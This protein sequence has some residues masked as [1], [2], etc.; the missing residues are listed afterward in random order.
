MLLISAGQVGNNGMK[1]EER[2][3]EIIHIKKIAIL[4]L[5]IILIILAI[6]LVLLKTFKI[7]TVVVEGNKHY[8]E[9]EIQDMVMGGRFGDNSLFL[10]VK[11]HNKSITDIPFIQ[12]MDVEVV[13]RNTIKISVYEKNLAG[14]VE[15]LGQ[16]MYFDK[17]GVIVET[18]NV[19]TEG[20]PLVTGLKFDHFV[21]YQTLP[22]EN[23]TIFKNILNVTKML[24]KYSIKTDRIYFSE[25]YDMTL[26]FGN[27]RVSIGDMELL[28]EKMQMLQSI[29][30]QLQDKKGLLEM[31]NYGEGSENITFTLDQ[32]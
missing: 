15:Y 31:S 6:I 16:Y 2:L 3:D 12:S 1:S 17:D 23:D 10:S 29:L 27:V 7:E 18:S 25:D 19:T 14:Y 30:P 20:I 22:V 8:T 5:G 26:Y 11:Y 9:Q 24:N 4:V 28:E 21:E 32:Q 13:N